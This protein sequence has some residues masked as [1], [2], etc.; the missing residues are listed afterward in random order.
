[1]QIIQD[2]VTG[3]PNTKNKHISVQKLAKKSLNT[4]TMVTKTMTYY[5][6]VTV[7]DRPM[8]TII[9]R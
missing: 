2:V 7:P 5:I 3:Q 9:H 1:M 8:V 6:S 4:V